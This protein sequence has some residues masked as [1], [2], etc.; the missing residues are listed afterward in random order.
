MKKNETTLQYTLINDNEYKRFKDEEPYDAIDFEEYKRKNQVLINSQKSSLF[1]SEYQ[2]ERA[3]DILKRRFNLN[4]KNLKD[5]FDE[6]CSGNG[7]EMNKIC[8][9]ISSSLCAFLHFSSVS[10]ETPITIN[11]IKYSEVHFEVKNKVFEKSSMPSNV[12]IMLISKDRKNILFLE[13]KFSEY[14]KPALCLTGVSKQY[15]PVYEEKKK[16]NDLYISTEDN[17]G[18]NI[19]VSIGDNEKHYYTGLQQFIAHYLGVCNFINGEFEEN[20]ETKKKYEISNSCHVKLGEIVFDGWEDEFGKYKSN[21]KDLAIILK[22]ITTKNKQRNLKVY[23]RM[24]TYQKLF[25]SDGPNAN[26]INDTIRK[27]YKYDE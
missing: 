8:T 18:K 16:Y 13:S 9:L 10:E 14:L 27:Y 25:K 24:F 23:T 15:K 3:L 11:K 1:F 17:N 6:A 26:L 20:R 12:D 21:Y 5:K 22:E 2:D 19:V 4:N 7:S